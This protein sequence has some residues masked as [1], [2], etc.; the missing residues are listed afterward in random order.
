VVHVGEALGGNG[1]RRPEQNRILQY[2]WLTGT[3]CVIR[4]PSH[5]DISKN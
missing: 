3:E 2:K 4:S 5:I 1:Q